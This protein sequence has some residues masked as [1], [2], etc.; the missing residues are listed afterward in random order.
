MPFEDRVAIVAGASGGIGAATVRAFLAQRY[1]VVLAAPPDALLDA[2]GARVRP[3]RRARADR[4]DG[5]HGAR[6]GRRARRA[7]ARGVRAD[8]RARERRGDRIEPVA[9]RLH[10]RRARTRARREPARRGA[11]DARGVAGDE[12]AAARRDRQRRL[13]G[14][15]GRRDGDLLGVEVR[16]ARLERLRAPRGA[17]LR[18]PRDAGRARLRADADEPVDARL[19][20]PG[21]R[22]GCDR[23][24]GVAPAPRARRARE[25][26]RARVLD[27][28]V[29]ALADVVFG[30]ARIQH[31]LN[32]DA[33]AERA[34]RA[35]ASS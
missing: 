2:A 10:R 28:D 12:G 15:R 27:E 5:H 4:A 25:L 6:R 23:R 13:G 7:R 22:G 8:R 30:S 31:R 24:R 29:P 11:A 3:A 18:R 32:R 26:S 35:A 9:V 34:A 14:R 33:R 1:R 19:A 21:D 17:Q 20:G 16:L